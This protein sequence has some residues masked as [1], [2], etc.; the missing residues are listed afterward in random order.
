MKKK[1]L[2]ELVQNNMIIG[3]HS[4]THRVL[5]KL[6]KKDCEKDISTSLD[7]VNNF[8]FQKTFC[9]PYGGFHTFNESIQKYLKKKKVSFSMNVESR[10]INYDEFFNKR[11][12]LP[13]YDCNN[14]IHGKITRN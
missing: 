12:S 7:F 14:F 9:Y 2:E 11:Y 13:R 1:H 4:H 6:R 8:N 10:D 5:S 3:A